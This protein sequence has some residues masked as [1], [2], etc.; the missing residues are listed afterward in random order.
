MKNAFTQWF[1][2]EICQI[3]KV[4]QDDIDNVT[5]YVGSMTDIDEI[6]DFVEEL[7]QNCNDR[8][9]KSYGESKK[10][11]INVLRNQWSRFGYTQTVEKNVTVYKKDFNDSNVQTVFK[12]KTDE[13]KV[14]KKNNYVP[15]YGKNGELHSKAV[16][17][18]GRNM[19]EC[20]AQKHKLINNCLSCGRIVC[21]QEGSGPC[22]FCGELVCT[23]D[24]KAIIM[25]KTKKSQKLH[26]KLMNQHSTNNILNDS[27]GLSKANQF[28][29]RLLEYDKS[30]KR[31]TKVIDDESD[32]YNVDNNN[33][34]SDKERKYLKNKQAEIYEQKYGS[35]RNRKFNFDFAGR[36]I[37]EDN[38]SNYDPTQDPA[39]LEANFSGF[40]LN[41]SDVDNKIIPLKDFDNFPSTV[42]P[43]DDKLSFSYVA[44]KTEKSEVLESKSE[45]KTNNSKPNRLQDGELLILSDH[46]L[47]LSM[48]QPWAS[49]L[50]HG[51][52]TDEGRN[53]YSSHRG[54][55][56]I[57]STSKDSSADEIE[58]VVKDHIDYLKSVGLPSDDLNLPAN[59]PSGCLLGCVDVKEV[60][61]QEEYR[62]KY[63]L[64]ASGS[65][66]VF[67]CKNPQELVLKIPIKGQHKIWKMDKLVHQ[68]AKKALYS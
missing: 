47:C 3:L 22:L 66:F 4:T 52:K 13:Q 15:L 53:W 17:L 40:N 49:L 21:D 42:Q 63:P 35:R 6:V 31:H 39:V 23:S 11:F 12:K 65:P 28:K 18:P 60:L 44:P 51:I 57:A 2:T 9:F 56:W 38:G 29:M 67:I 55:L 1:S 64:G 36:T 5:S 26:N 50:I 20:Q 54:R 61:D 33:W 68:A 41:Q 30:H 46:G 25:Q 19:C 58:S 10:E 43:S 45:T 16:M 27:A 37:I 32:Y 8:R 62:E 7:L 48:H 59:Y 34:L 14:R 24:E